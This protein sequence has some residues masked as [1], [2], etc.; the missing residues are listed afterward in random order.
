MTE[1]PAL[2]A[3][4]EIAAFVETTVLRLPED[5]VIEIAIVSA[6]SAD[7]VSVKRNQHG[8]IQISRRLFRAYLMQSLLEAAVALQDEE[9]KPRRKR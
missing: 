1:A 4:A 6:Q 9:G 3:A 8:T 2:S 7:G 5:A